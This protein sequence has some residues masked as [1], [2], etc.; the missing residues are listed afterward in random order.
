[1]SDNRLTQY[2][3]LL[4]AKAANG[5]GAVALV[6]D[7]KSMNFNFIAPALSNYTIKFV[8]SN[9]TTRPDFTAA[10]SATN[11][12]NTVEVI[13]LEDGN[14]IDGDTG[15]AVAGAVNRSFEVNTNGIRWFAAIISSYVA[16]TATVNYRAFTSE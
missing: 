10:Q 9:Q 15:I 7:Y 2:G 4:N 14:A 11:E 3:N 6:E 12:W 8:K 1:M 5:I 16:G 13:D